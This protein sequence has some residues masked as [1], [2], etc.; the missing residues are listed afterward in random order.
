M[1]IAGLF[2]AVTLVSLGLAVMTGMRSASDMGD[3]NL[4]HNQALSYMERL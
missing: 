4:V 2:L 1:L 3:R